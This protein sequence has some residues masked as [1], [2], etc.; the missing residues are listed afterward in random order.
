MLE[1]PAKSSELTEQLRER[2][3]LGGP[4]TFRDWMQAALYDPRGGYYRRPDLT[5][6]GREGDYR[7]SP[8]RSTLFAATFARYFAGLYEE[9]GRPSS[10]TILEAGAGDGTLA[11]GILRTL[12]SQFPQV[13]FATSYVIDEVSASSRALAQKRLGQFGERVAFKRLDDVDVDPGVVFSNEL[14]DAFPVHRLTM[15]GGELKEMFVDVGDNGAFE[16]LIAEPSTPCLV[17]HFDELGIR[18]SDG[19][20]VEVN[21]EIEAWLRRVSA[22]LKAGYLVTVDYGATAAE[23]YSASGRGQGTLRAFSRHEFVDDLL[24]GPGEHDLTSTVNWDFVKSAG[25]R[26]GL[27]VVEFERQD[28]FLLAAGFLQ[29]LEV[30]S[31]QC[32]GDADRLRLSTTAREMILPDGMAAHF[33][34]LVQRKMG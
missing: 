14:L 19:Q 31:S 20:V 30:Q 4:I 29:Q 10:W 6:W 21:L 27:E 26:L 33:Q 16:W 5:K 24:T 32:V 23:L 11:H 12:Q 2:I 7:T 17:E 28:K 9:L 1:T 8:E 25:A 34:V 15:R 18:L 3:R 22:R 13:F